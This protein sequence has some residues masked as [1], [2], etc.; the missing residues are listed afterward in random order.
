ML[1]LLGGC[2]FY[3]NELY[4]YP[5]GSATLSYNYSFVVLCFNRKFRARMG[6]LDFSFSFPG[7]SSYWIL[8]VLSQAFKH[9][10]FSLFILLALVGEDTQVI[11]RCPSCWAL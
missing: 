10:Y 7:L 3:P 5:Y 6:N 11:L 4:V 8:W 9:T 2:Q 1:G